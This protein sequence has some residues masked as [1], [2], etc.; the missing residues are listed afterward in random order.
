MPP[1]ARITDFHLCPMLTGLCP[2]VGGLIVTG[3]KSVII[4]YM[5]AARIGDTAICCC[6]PDTIAV[7]SSSVIIGYKPAAR[8]LDSTAH[9]GKIVTGVPQVIIGG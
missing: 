5:P 2:H 9:G 1:A 4:S 3:D 8:T 7:G 6:A